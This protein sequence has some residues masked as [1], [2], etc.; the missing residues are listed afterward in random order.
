MY[1]SCGGHIYKYARPLV[2]LTHQLQ[3]FDHLHSVAHQGMHANCHLVSSMYIWAGLAIEV[4]DWAYNCLNCQRAKVICHIHIR[5]E[6]IHIC[7]DKNSLPHLAVI[8]HARG[9]CRFPCPSPMASPT[10]SA[11]SS[12]EHQVGQ[13]LPLQSTTTVACTYAL[14]HGP[15]RCRGRSSLSPSG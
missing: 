15:H 10:H 1:R 2:P 14:F 4:S 7:P 6:L 3:V 9:S 13:S 12:R 8:P 11:P 5:P